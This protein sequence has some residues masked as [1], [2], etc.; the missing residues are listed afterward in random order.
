MTHPW[1]SM[2]CDGN[3]LASYCV[4]LEDTLQRG[5]A[6]PSFNNGATLP[7]SYSTEIMKCNINFLSSLIREG[8]DLKQ[9]ALCDQHAATVSPDSSPIVQTMATVID[10]QWHSCSFKESRPSLLIFHL[11]HNRVNIS[12]INYTHSIVYRFQTAINPVV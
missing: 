3:G 5:S 7:F 9:I 10:M 12:T 6:S 11:G 1:L 2:S 4:L 8:W